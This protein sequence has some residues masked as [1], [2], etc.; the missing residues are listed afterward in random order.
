MADSDAMNPAAAHP[1]GDAS[2]RFS[3]LHGPA[4]LH[5]ALLA[6]L[7]PSS[8]RAAH[9]WEVETAGIASA[10]GLLGHATRLSGAARLP[11]VELLLSRMALQPLG[12]RQELLQ[13]TRRIMGAR[14]WVRPIDRLHWLAMRRGLGEVSTLPIRAEAHTEVAEWLETD[15]LSLATYTAYLSRMVPDERADGVAGARW[16]AIVMTAWQPFADAPDCQPPTGEQ[17]AEALSRLQTL[18]LMQRPVVV[19]SWVTTALRVT[20]GARLEDVSADALRLSC[21]LL[22]SPLPPELARHYITLPADSTK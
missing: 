21:N 9:A 7:L 18:S 19:R 20:A 5:A 10:E 4:E 14:G 8:K 16:Y 11:W 13:A 22:D 2:D 6:L 15:V 17:M 1:E 12:V 3:R